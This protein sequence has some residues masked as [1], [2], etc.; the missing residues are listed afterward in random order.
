MKQEEPM[1]LQQAT[2]A[3]ATIVLL[4]A[5]EGRRFGGV[6]QLAI[7]HGE[8]MVH[9][10]TRLLAETGAPVVVVIGAHA[11]DVEAALEDLP[12]YRV[13]NAD[14]QTGMGTSL[15]AGFR[16]VREHFTAVTGA[17]LCLADQPMPDAT[18]PIRM[19]RRHSQAPDRLLAVAQGGTVGPPVLFPHDCFAELS[20]RSGATGA[21]AL[22]RRESRRLETF[23][24]DLLPDIDT[25]EDLE[26][27][28]GQPQHREK[29]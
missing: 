18:L 14:W 17:L 28:A 21:Q 11:E 5:G 4:A 24:V 20:V 26:R 23:A 15:A 9:R 10:A 2:N 6:K 22:L 16:H 8:P 13:R 25:P 3:N 29:G 1:S 27:A 12:V 7:L 19:L